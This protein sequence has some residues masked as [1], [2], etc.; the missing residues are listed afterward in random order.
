[1]SMFMIDYNCIEA[2][3]KRSLEY[4]SLEAVLYHYFC[5]NEC[6]RKL[7]GSPRTRDEWRHWTSSKKVVV[8]S[9]KLAF[10]VLSNYGTPR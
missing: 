5:F 3:E 10:Q 1:M 7:F 9:R 2:D 8:L 6:C 4:F